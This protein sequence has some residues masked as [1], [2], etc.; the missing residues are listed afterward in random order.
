M[1][2]TMSTMKADNTISRPAC[3]LFYM[4]CIFE[5]QSRLAI[6]NSSIEIEML[7]DFIVPAVFSNN[8]VMHCLSDLSCKSIS[9]L[10]RGNIDRAH[11]S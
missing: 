9:C 2:I 5:K 3:L 7:Q 10:R 8:F 4:Q 1:Q 6:L 11:V